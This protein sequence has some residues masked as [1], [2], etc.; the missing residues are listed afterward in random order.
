[1]IG[2]FGWKASKASVAHQ[3][4][5][6]YLHDMGI[7][8]PLFPLNNCDIEQSECLDA[9]QEET[10]EIRQ[11]LFDK[12]VLYSSLLAVP[13]RREWTDKEVLHGKR[14][15]HNIGCDS[16]HIPNFTTSCNTALPEVACQ[17]IWPYTDLLLHDMGEGLADQ[18]SHS[19]TLRREWRTPPLWGIGFIEIVNG[20][21][22]FL[23]DGRARSL[24]EAIL[25]HGG[26]GNVSKQQYIDLDEQDRSRIV[27]FLESL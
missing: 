21:T 7:T 9:P 22:R 24:E 8:N 11:E 1:M 14:L 4:G 13:M 10:I 15:F 26:E 19:H 2:R 12:V 27:A 16:C 25:W 20:H 18:E 5:A 3:V 6:A 17:N 23:H